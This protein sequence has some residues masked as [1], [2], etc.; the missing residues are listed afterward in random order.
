MFHRKFKSND[1]QS[2]NWSQTSGS[3]QPNPYDKFIYKVIV[4][5]LSQIIKL[6]D[7]TTNLLISFSYYSLVC[8]E[9]NHY[10][11][12]SPLPHDYHVAKVKITSL[13]KNSDVL[14]HVAGTRVATFCDVI[15]TS[16]ICQRQITSQH[17]ELTCFC[18]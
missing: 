18:A 6:K 14:I 13:V 1:S 15:N 5:P 16:L 10:K 17:C 11:K 8:H 4:I 3:S 2:Q 12:N 7:I 9:N